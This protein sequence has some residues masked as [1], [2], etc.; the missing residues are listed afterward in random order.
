MTTGEQLSA[1]V[2]G[3]LDAEERAA[4]E[5]ALEDDAQLRER[6]GRLHRSEEALSALPAVEPPAGFSDELHATLDRE[7]EEHGSAGGADE[8]A[9]RRRSRFEALRPLGVAAAAA[10]VIALFGVAG[11]W[12][13]QGGGGSGDEAASTAMDAPD[14]GQV[15][16]VETDNDYD[17]QQLRRVAVNAEIRTLVPQDFTAQE[18]RPLAERLQSDLL[19]RADGGA[20][21]VPAPEGG[22]AAEDSAEGDTSADSQTFGTARSEVVG[23]APVEAV[24]RCLSTVLQDARAPLVPVYVELARFKGA[25]AVIYTLV[26]EDPES[27]TYQRVEVWAV[28]PNDCQVLSFAQYDRS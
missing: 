7:L 21:A 1:Y 16:V 23:A 18:A 8:L 4:V 2:A 22:E 14:L 27:G 25:P 3:E 9:A 28:S 20:G 17:E 6:L 13:L 12:L 24:G 26:S 5:A 11:V 15:P 10:A 19:D